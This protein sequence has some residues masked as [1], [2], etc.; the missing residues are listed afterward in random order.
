MKLMYTTLLCLFLASISQ[1]QSIFSTRISAND[2]DL[3]EY[4]PSVNQTKTVGAMDAG[5]SDLELGN[6]AAANKDP[7]LVGLRFT[8]ITIPKGAVITKAYLRFTVDATGK[9]TDPCNLFVYAQ[10]ADNP[11]TFN[12]SVSF[13]ISSRLQLKDSVAWNIAAGSWKTVGEAGT[14][15]TSS[16]ISR[17]VR[18]L[19]N[20]NGWASGNAMAFFIKGTGLREADAFDDAPATAAQLVIEY[21]VPATLSYRIAENDDDLEEYLPSANQTKTVGAMDV[22]SSDLE[23]GNEVAANK[24][25]QL[26]G[27]RFKNIDLPQNATITNAYIQFTVDAT[28]KNTDPCNLYIYAQ[29]ADNPVT[30]NPS[31]PFN[32]SSR[33]QIKDSVAWNIAATSWKT[34]GEA[35]ADQRSSNITALIQKLV[36]RTG[37]QKGNAMAFF[38][39]GTGLREADAFDDAPATA[40]QLV[41]EY[42]SSGG[43]TVIVPTNPITTYPIK[44]GSTWN[45]FDKGTA[46]NANWTSLNF[47]D[48]TW[49]FNRAPMGYGTKELLTTTS[50]GIDTTNKYRTTYFRKKFRVPDFYLLSDTLQIALRADDG[51]VVYLNGQRVA[52]V[53]MPAGTIADTTLATKE[54]SYPDEFLYFVYDIP[55]TLLKI[56][57]NVIAV[58][59]HQSSKSGT[60]I[61]FDLKFSNRT[62]KNVANLGC[63]DANDKHIGCFTSIIALP[64]LDTIT[65]PQQHAFQFLVSNNDNFIGATGTVPSNFDF[66][67]YVPINNNSRQGYLSINHERDPIGGNSVANIRFDNETGLW[68]VDSLKP[69]DFTSVVKTQANCSGGITPWGTVI[70]S[71]ESISDTLDTNRDG[72]IDIGW[73]VEIN[74]ATKT[75]VKGQKLWAMGRMSHENV[76]VHKDQKT[77]YQGEDHPTGCVYK[78]VANTEK[79]L[80]SGK[81]YVLK[82]TGVTN[83]TTVKLYKNFNAEGEPILTTGTW[84]EVP[85]TTIAERNNVKA[86]ATELGGTLFNGVEDVEISPIDGKIYFAVKGNPFA[87]VYRFKDE[88][89]TITAFETFVGGTNYR[90]NT[91]NKVIDEDWGSGNDNLTFDDRGNLWVLQDGSRDHVWV[92]RPEHTQTSPK[93]ETFMLT[94]A[95]SEPTGMTFSPDYRYMFLSIQE[96]TASI[97]A[98]Q[99]D[100]AGKTDKFN[101]SHALV[102]ARKEYLGI[103]QST[104]IVELS[105]KIKVVAYPNPTNGETHILLD[106]NCNSAK[107]VR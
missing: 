3:E 56:D 17:L 90:M 7:Q 33:P 104:S 57:T 96:P 106:L 101:R 74:P 58:E 2:D 14:D 88:G 98:I 64:K 55:S 21:G 80:S 63:K 25:P 100:V 4:L 37:W 51:A 78:F 105:D 92:I 19:I 47:N 70:T 60:D 66:T 67:A 35:G 41:I 42:L 77:V 82:L 20:R 8:N 61:G 1:S 91:G 29:D 76:V 40:A 99:K 102:V 83:D 36:S 34:V 81:L 62:S 50:F 107:K 28:G 13:N 12:P 97:T 15:Q 48:T 16:D 31:V 45:Y 10:D 27:L 26:V 87:R 54:V 38:I 52:S 43:A 84:I 18:A 65:I 71:E 73:N 68:K 9:N 22:G 24:D 59:V 6:E 93:V 79:D 53:N 85:N 72:Y 95:G 86:K 32:I 46:P 44:S 75:I 89:T 94:P 11:L 23:L 5:S 49:A 39:K 69:I 30:F 103:K